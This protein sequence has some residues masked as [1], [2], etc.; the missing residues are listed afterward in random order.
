MVSRIGLTMRVTN[1]SRYKE[2]RDALAQDWYAYM[3]FAFRDIKWLMIP[4]LGCEV[5]EYI[6]SWNLD[7]FILTGGNNI[8]EAPQRDDTESILL[9]YAI[10][11]RYPVFGVCRGMQMIQHYFKGILSSCV[12]E[13]HVATTHPVSFVRSIDGIAKNGDVQ[14]VNSYHT[15]A[16]AIENLATEL[17]PFAV[18]DDGW[19]EGLNCHEHLISAVQWHPERSRPFSGLDKQMIRSIFQLRH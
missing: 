3:H 16:I 18:T 15:Q 10:E 1:V 11:N 19:V 7:G 17:E 5:V 12:R 4:N 9:S 8:G 14:I 2:G 6:R 13:K